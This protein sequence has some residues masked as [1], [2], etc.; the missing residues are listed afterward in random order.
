MAAKKA[1]L[2]HETR[3]GILAIVSIAL[4]IWGYTYLKG[5]NMLSTSNLIYV[6]YPSVDMLSASS[7]VL[8]NG[9]QI[10]VVADMYLKEEDM[11]TIIVV[12][13]I[14]RGVNIPKNAVA[15][16]ISTDVMGGKGIRMAFTQPCTGE[17][18]VKNGDYIQG[19]VMGLLGSMIPQDELS[20]YL[21]QVSNAVGELLDTLSNKISDP[22]A[23]GV[24]ESI[25]NFNEL[26]ANL[27]ILILNSS[28]SIESTM[29]HLSSIMG[30]IDDDNEKISAFLT[31]VAAFSEQLNKLDLDKTFSNLNGTMT[32]A[33]SA[34]VELK[35]TLLSA[36]EALASISDLVRGVKDGEGTM[37]KF[38]TNDSLYYNINNA[39]LQLEVLLKDFEEKP[40]RYMPLKSRNKVNRY[41]SKDA[42]QEGN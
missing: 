16:I 35:E 7:P 5:R 17:D 14:K 18:C 2:S 39:S 34:I 8:I 42:K 20:I 25:R 10:G 15:E 31:N 37:G 1:F 11:R 40:Y 28:R 36:N 19:R 4:L 12:L 41:D 21:N 29:A 13:D 32:N 30:K 33:D 24:A 26:T 27:N 3:I 38:F 9:F 23:K 6:E 22:E